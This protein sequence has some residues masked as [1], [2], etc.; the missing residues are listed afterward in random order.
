MNIYYELTKEP[1]AFCM[2][3]LMLSNKLPQIST[4]LNLVTECIYIVRKMY[5]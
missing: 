4:Y 3:Q 1:A 5:G 2:I